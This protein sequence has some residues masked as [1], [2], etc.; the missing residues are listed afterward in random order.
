MREKLY[1]AIYTINAHPEYIYFT[2]IVKIEGCGNDKD[3]GVKYHYGTIPRYPSSRF[4]EG[5][6]MKVKKDL[7]DFIL[8]AYGHQEFEILDHNKHLEIYE[9]SHDGKKGTFY[10]REVNHV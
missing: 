5:R 3:K 1:K 7:V 4:V 9:K 10:S 8:S 6:E 2:L